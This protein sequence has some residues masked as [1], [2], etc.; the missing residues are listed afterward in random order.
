MFFF[1]PQRREMNRAACES[2]T[3]GDILSVFCHVS[4][5]EVTDLAACVFLLPHKRKSPFSTAAL[6]LNL[7]RDGCRLLTTHSTLL[8]ILLFQV[9]VHQNTKLQ[10]TEK[11]CLTNPTFNSIYRSSGLLWSDQ[12]GRSSI[13]ISTFPSV[14]SDTGALSAFC[15]YNTP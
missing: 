8:F 9:C 2:D 15:H 14:A 4:S 7:N 1:S 10:T 11:L 12:D 13:I 5:V 3:W 6:K